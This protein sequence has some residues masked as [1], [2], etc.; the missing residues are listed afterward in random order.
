MMLPL[1]IPLYAPSSSPSSEPNLAGRGGATGIS[2]LPL[3][4]LDW[5]LG[6]LPKF[7]PASP[8]GD[9]EVG[10]ELSKDM[11]PRCAFRLGL[12]LS[13]GEPALGVA[14]MIFN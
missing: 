14:A 13:K 1:S 7:P 11:E 2:C 9:G 4:D 3:F 10:D 8:V 12:L 5:E 6:L